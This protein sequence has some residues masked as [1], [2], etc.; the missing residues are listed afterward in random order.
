MRHVNIITC[1]ELEK[2]A[3]LRPYERVTISQEDTNKK[4][5]CGDAVDDANLN[6]KA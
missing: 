3:R 6:Y 1:M 2:I 5:A 4:R